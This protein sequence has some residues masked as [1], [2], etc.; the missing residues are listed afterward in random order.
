MFQGVVHKNARDIINAWT[1]G[2]KKS[3]HIG[4]VGNF[5]IPSL[6]RSNGFKN[7]ITGCDVSL[8]STLLGNAIQDKDTELEI[9]HGGYLWLEPYLKTPDDKIAT[10]SLMLDMLQFVKQDNEY[11]VKMWEEYL[12][13]FRELHTQTVEKVKSF[14]DTVQPID[15]QAMDVSEYLDGIKDGLILMFPPTYKNGYERMYRKIDEIFLWDRPDYSVIDSFAPLFKKTIEK[16]GVDHILLSEYLDEELVNLLGFPKAKT[17]RSGNKYIYLWTNLHVHSELINRGQKLES[18]PYK[19]FSKLELARKSKVEVLE[20]KSTEAMYLRSVF[21]SKE[22]VPVPAD[23]DIGLFI[24]G[25]LFFIFGFSNPNRPSVTSIKM[26]DC[27]YMLYDLPVV[28][29]DKASKLNLYASLSEEVRQMVRCKFLSE[30]KHLAT[31]AFSKNPVSMK[32][33]GLFEVLKRKEQNGK[34]IINYTANA[35]KWTLKQ[36][37]NHWYDKHGKRSIK[38][39][40]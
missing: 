33:R 35:G 6:L 5:T 34:F 26:E 29:I 27:V 2:Y 23:F 8:Y 20:I 40:Q 37:F 16:H 12:N 7:P 38:E 13:G 18:C 28:E 10:I 24:D 22:I 17:H 15:Y 9:C 11:K 21:L 1:Q 14:R 30:I 36:G 19:R 31:T 39:N 25:E 3:A 4:C 32:Y